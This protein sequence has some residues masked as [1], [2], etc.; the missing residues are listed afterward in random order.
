MKCRP[1][2]YSSSANMAGL[3]SFTPQL[4]FEYMSHFLSSINVSGHQCIGY[5]V[6]FIRISIEVKDGGVRSVPDMSSNK[7]LL[8]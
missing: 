2:T 7:A 4:M 1:T 8:P 6:S 3:R 5:T